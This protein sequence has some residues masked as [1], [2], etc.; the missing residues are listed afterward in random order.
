MA[1][2]PKAHIIQLPRRVKDQQTGQWVTRLDDYLEVKWRVV[3]F[4]EKYPHGSI[5]TEEICVDLDKGYAR[6]KAHVGDG[7]GGI[8]T[9]YGTETVKDFADFAERAET[10]AIGRALALLGFG[11]QFVGTDLTEGD[12]VADAPVAPPNGH[13]E[14]TTSD[15]VSAPPLSAGEPSSPAPP[16][17]TADQVDGL[18]EL[19]EKG[20]HEPKDLL[21]RRLKEIMGVPAEAKITKKL[22]RETMTPAQYRVAM[23]YYEQLLK[24]QVEEDVPDA[25]PPAPA[26][27]E[28]GG[29]QAPFVSSS[30]APDPNAEAKAKLRA[31]VATWTLPVSADEIE[32]I[33]NH[34][35]PEKARA[36]LWGARRPKPAAT[37]I[38]AA[39][40]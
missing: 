31:E 1:F 17:L 15:V 27:A 13:H 38:E 34:Y 30:S 18:F 25:E 29:V 19:A 4:R 24:K 11:T 3:M 8:A 28:K 36:L 9:G 10:R 35:A 32:Y 37:P 2:D 33:L 12:H 14:L 39:A 5:I 26:A 22:V 40:D 20:C 7:E 23:A 21:G 16:Q 6:Y